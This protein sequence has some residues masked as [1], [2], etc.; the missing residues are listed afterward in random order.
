MSRHTTFRIGGKADV[1][2]SPAL[3]QAIDIIS[4]CRRE[5][6]PLTILGN[7]SNVLVGDKGIPGVVLSFGREAGEIEVSESATDDTNSLHPQDMT[8][9]GR[10]IRAQAGALLS[11]VANAAAEHNLTGLEFAAGIPGTVGGA[12]LMN[13]GAYGGEMK[14][15]VVR[16]EVMLPDGEIQTWEKDALELSYRH[17][18]M[19][20]TGAI[21]LSVTLKLQKGSGAAIRERMQQLREQRIEKQP[22]EYPSAGSTF[23][24]PKGYFA[25]KLIMDAGLRG[26]AI[27][28][29]AVS[30]KHCGFVINKGSATAAQV[31]T[32]MQDVSGQVE[33]QFGVT[34]EPEVV[35]LG[36]F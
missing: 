8:D 20:D 34:L 10:E 33:K 3:D 23:K 13:A 1:F 36:E 28:D 17:S 26:Y 12:L 29:A 11:Q 7:G 19:M 5:N 18:R 31:R 9:E 6:I 15:V 2:V 4:Y 27:G 30:E 16:V 24:R 32:L 21:I 22:L 25:G 14:D 35:F